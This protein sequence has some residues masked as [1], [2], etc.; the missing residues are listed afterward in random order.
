MNMKT[1]LLTGTLALALTPGLLAAEDTIGYQAQPS[2][3][4]MWII[5]RATG[6]EWKMKSVIISGS[7]EAD[8]AW[9]K[10]PS[11]KSVTCLGDGKAPKCQVSI[12]VRT[13]KSQVSVGKSIMDGRAQKEMNATRYPNIVYTL[14]EMKIKGDVPAS[15]SPVQF[16]TK[17][18][19]AI[20]GV[21]NEVAFPVTMERAGSDTV[22]FTGEYKTKMTAFKVEPPEFTILGIGSK[23]EDDITLKWTWTLT[24]VKK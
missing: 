5:G 23:T 2:G 18:K 24:Q 21:T 14:T 4:E 13:L 20:A 3:S 7:F 10:D 22:K 8:A 16:D 17:G 12:P 9:A 11:L 1:L 19:L 6:H 15:G